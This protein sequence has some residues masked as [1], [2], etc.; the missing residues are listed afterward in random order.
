MTSWLRQRE[1]TAGGLLYWLAQLD[2]PGDRA[3]TARP[4]KWEPASR[5][6]AGHRPMGREEYSQ[7]ILS[8]DVVVEALKD[9]SM[10][11]TRICC[12]SLATVFLPAGIAFA[13]VPPAP[14]VAPA[15][16]LNPSS[17][18]VVP[19]PGAGLPVD[20]GVGVRNG[21]VPAWHQR[22]GQSAAQ[23]AAPSPPASARPALVQIRPALIAARRD[24]AFGAAPASE[25]CHRCRVLRQFILVRHETCSPSAPVHARPGLFSARRDAAVAL[26]ALSRRGGHGRAI[27]SSNVASSPSHARTMPAAPSQGAASRPGLDLRDQ[28]RWL[29]HSCSARGGARAAVHAPRHR[30]YRP[31][32]KDCCRA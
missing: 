14:Y 28:A 6:P 13:Q 26:K 3:V 22:G 8:Y 10:Y 17:S 19:A 32:S 23:R 25:P 20:F 18:L 11:F 21:R 12:L 29:P 4:R 16:I 27:S 15:P 9:R 5:R 30:F 2:R 1:V 31:L 24:C 7:I